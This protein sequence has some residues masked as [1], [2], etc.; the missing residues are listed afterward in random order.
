MTI[1]KDQTNIKFT[2]VELLVVIAIIAILASF[3][4][5]AIATARKAAL[6]SVCL[7]NIKQIT[8]GSL[9]YSADFNDYI[10]PDGIKNLNGNT[11][12]SMASYWMPLIYTYVAGVDY[13]KSSWGEN[14]YI[15][16]PGSFGKSIFCCPMVDDAIKNRMHLSI[17]DRLP[18]GIN[19]LNLNYRDSKVVWTRQSSI[20]MPSRTIIY[21]D[22]EPEKWGYS[23]IMSPPYWW[24]DYYVPSL[25]HGTSNT[26]ECSANSN[27]R[28]NMSFIDGHVKS[29]C[30]FDMY[31]DYQNIFRY[32]KK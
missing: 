25:R 6:D 16:F 4:I 10:P 2:L 18:Y 12:R 21:G 11:S 17:A 7:N 19:F 30:F 1:H 13:H 28:S 14:I 27:G 20:A 31:I 22:S 15:Y 5:P 8:T 9:I 24:G 32:E 29:L 26:N 3:S 23:I